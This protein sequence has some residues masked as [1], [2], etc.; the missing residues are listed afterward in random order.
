MPRVVVRQSDLSAVRAIL[1]GLK[2]DC[3]IS[4][5]GE[6][7][8]RIEVENEDLDFVLTAMNRAKIDLVEE[9]S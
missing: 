5:F 8:A 9:G 1:G 2:I 3:K 7:G 4:D 6:R